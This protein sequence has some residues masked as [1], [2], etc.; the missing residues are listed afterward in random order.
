MSSFPVPVSPRIKTVEPVGA[1][2]STCLRT[3]FSAWLS[4]TNSL[5]LWQS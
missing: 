2:C 1:T 4:P 3:R 5:N